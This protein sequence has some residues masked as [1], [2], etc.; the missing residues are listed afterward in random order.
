MA[1]SPPRPPGGSDDRDG[2]PK[3]DQHYF[4]LPFATSDRIIE[5]VQ[6]GRI[7]AA[8]SSASIV[9]TFAAVRK[10]FLFMNGILT[11]SQYPLDFIKSRMQSYAIAKSNLSPALTQISYGTKLIPTVTEAYHKE[12]IR[13]FWRGAYNRKSHIR[14]CHMLTGSRRFAPSPERHHST[15]V[16]VHPLQRDQDSCC[17]RG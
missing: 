12:G 4:G 15:D 17:Q 9:S 10:E 11:A 2:R 5:L 8:S 14:P 1:T 13:T 16:L 6:W 7:P 3:T